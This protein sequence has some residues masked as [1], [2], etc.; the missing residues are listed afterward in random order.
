MIRHARPPPLPVRGLPVSVIQPA[1][2]AALVAGS[3]DAKPVPP[4]QARAAS[5]AVDV[6]PPAALADEEP[7]P[8]SRA[9][10][11]PQRLH[12]PLAGTVATGHGRADVSGSKAL[13]LLG[14][15]LSSRYSWRCRGAR[16]RQRPGLP[17]VQGSSPLPP[18]PNAVNLIGISSDREGYVQILTLLDERRH[19]TGGGDWPAGCP[20][21]QQ[22]P[23]RSCSAR[24][25]G[26]SNR[27]ARGIDRSNCW[28]GPP[29]RVQAAQHVV[30]GT[31]DLVQALD[32]RSKFLWRGDRNSVANALDGEGAYLA[33]FD[34][35]PLGEV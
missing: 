6:A 28:F 23:G 35:G 5:A 29:P 14:H 11:V 22:R 10:P 9:R 4:G 12:R 19:P 17:P 1:L 2:R 15:S 27:R 18:S 25:A 30:S 21:V 7:L 32:D 33:D 8:A 20:A 31:D 24:S 34:P 26:R 13:G 3:D 16:A